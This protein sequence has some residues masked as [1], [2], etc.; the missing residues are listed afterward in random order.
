MSSWPVSHQMQPKRT[1]SPLAAQER[2]CSSV[3]SCARLK[4]FRGATNI[5]FGNAAL[6]VIEHQIQALLH[7][8]IKAMG[9]HLNWSPL[10]GRVIGPK[11]IFLC[12]CCLRPRQRCSL[13]V[14]DQDAGSQKANTCWGC[15]Q[16]FLERYVSCILSCLVAF[17]Y[18]RCSTKARYEIDST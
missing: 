14:G 6:L 15:G 9:I 7:Q 11:A 13:G 18:K 2:S 3:Q 12:L 17:L 4:L 1:Q 5:V 8:A 16:N 10:K